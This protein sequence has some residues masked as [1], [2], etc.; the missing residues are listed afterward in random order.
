M[1]NILEKM[2]YVPNTNE[3]NK[4][5][6]VHGDPRKA[7]RRSFAEK[8]K[9]IC[10]FD[11]VESSKHIRGSIRKNGDVKNWFGTEAK[12]DVLFKPADISD[13]QY[14]LENLPKNTPIN[15]IGAASNMIVCEKV[16]GVVIRLGREFAKIS[17]EGE[18]VKAGAAALCG[19][20]AL[21]S[22]N[23]ALTNL[24]FLTGIPGSIGGA[25][26]MN[27]GCYGSEIKDF[28]IEAK[29]IDFAGNL[30]VFSNENFA[31]HYR[32]S[33]LVN[34][35]KNDFKGGLIFVEATFQTTK[36]TIEA[37]AAKI[38]ECNKK[39]EESQPIRAKTSGSTFRNPTEQTDKRSW[40][41]IDEAG[42]RGATVG[43]AQMSEKHCNFMLNCGNASSQDLIDLAHKVQDAVK[44]NSGVDLHFEIKVVK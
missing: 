14:F 43:D 17:N 40:Q 29:A 20:V 7:G 4:P 26:A 36:S 25:V 30:H 44:K 37:V 8:N 35:S 38:D 13:L 32:G 16:S 6:L 23:E 24:E 10:L 34:R 27:A 9:E 12:A 1:D 22:K 31:F 41:L 18:I 33:D 3:N 11:S 5:C 15:V 39:R 28:L 2:P 21:H 19:N 42:C